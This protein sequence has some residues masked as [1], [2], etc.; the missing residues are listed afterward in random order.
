SDTTGAGF[1][2]GN[3]AQYSWMVPFDLASLIKRRGGDPASLR[4]LNRFVTRLNA[5]RAGS[6]SPHA[7][8]GNEPSLGTPWIFDWLRKPYRTQQV[9]RRALLRYWSARPGGEPGEDDLGELSSWYVLSALGVYPSTP[10]VGVLTL[11]GPLFAHE[12]LHLG[13]SS[14]VIDARGAGSRAP[15]IH[16]LRIDGKP[17]SK[18]WIPYCALA[19][20]GHLAFRMS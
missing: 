7:Y 17:R 12:R 13:T 18:P 11:A 19:S 16:S 5:T 1:A 14:T 20:G 2:E 15:Y 9:V 8:L 4:A 6:R 10:G 3:S